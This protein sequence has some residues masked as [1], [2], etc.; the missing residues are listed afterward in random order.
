[1]RP[2]DLYV[3]PSLASEPWHETYGLI[4]PFF[5]DEALEDQLDRES[6]RE[7]GD[8][9]VVFETKLYHYGDG[10]RTLTY[11]AVT[12]DGHDV[13]ILVTAGRGGSERV[14]RIVTR[15]DLYREAKFYLESRRAL[16][17][18]P[19]NDFLALDAE[20]EILSGSHGYLTLPDP[21]GGLRLVPQ[22]HC[23]QGRMA[24][25]EIAFRDAFEAAVARRFPPGTQRQARDLS[26]PGMLAAATEAMGASLAN[27][28]V[29]IPVAEGEAP[30]QSD[31]LGTTV[32]VAT[33]GVHRVAIGIPRYM[34]VRGFAWAG[35]IEVAEAAASAA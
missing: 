26:D 3:L 34:P 8:A 27:G 7:K 13:G 21:R 17:L 28:F 14:K 19:E 30:P 6:A 10:N 24:F 12:W 18:T 16:D 2:V 20:A 4:A 35:A 32:L 15:L 1:M 25:D 9:R 31:A 29:A 23:W 33:D 5:S 22:R 11:S